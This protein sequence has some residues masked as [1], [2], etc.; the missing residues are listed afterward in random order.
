[1][2]DIF[3]K[4]FEGQ[5]DLIPSQDPDPYIP[6][7][8]DARYN[9]KVTTVTSAEKI[10]NYTVKQWPTLVEE[11]LGG[12]N[13]LGI[14]LDAIERQRKKLEDAKKLEE[15]QNTRDSILEASSILDEELEGAPDDIKAPSVTVEEL[16]RIRA[17]AYEEGK[18]QGLDDGYKAGFEEGLA[19]GHEEGFN[20]G[21]EDGR[22]K[23]YEQGLIQGNE[24]GFLKG[25]SEG[26]ES[27]RTIVLE[28]AER[29]RYLSDCLANP[30]REVDRDVTDE[31]AY[32]ISRLVKV[33][34]KREI[35]SNQDY[36]KSAIDKAISVLPNA[37]KGATVYL[38]PE[39]YAVIIANIGADYARAQN[40]DLK[41]DAALNPGDIR[42]A[43]EYSEIDWKIDD[44]IDSLLSDFLSK[45][46]PAVDKALRESIDGCPE[47]DE[48][49]KK[50]AVA[51]SLSELAQEV[52]ENTN[53]SSAVENIQDQ[54]MDKNVADA[55]LEPVNE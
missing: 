25:Q 21:V 2:D 42:V 33:I 34:T 55:S 38:N 46:Y 8:V 18:A 40:W 5:S 26:L 30:L 53:E 7:K 47:Y 51:S 54:P 6:V 17:D 12:T 9:R 52:P 39:D 3:K 43:N 4:E 35:S 50:P 24:D 22:A 36:L 29:F 16:D 19:K 48:I 31:I 11:D 49:P 28:Q 41:E 1:M 20:S 37:D 14:S 10:S 32:I 27:G 13:A 44:R 45:T 15:Q 23:G